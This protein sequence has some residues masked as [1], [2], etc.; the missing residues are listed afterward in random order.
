MRTSKS[1]LAGVAAGALGLALVPALGVTSANAASV[2][3]VTSPVRA[4]TV[5]SIPA[6]TL[7]IPSSVSAPTTLTVVSAPTAAAMVRINNGATPASTDDSASLSSGAHTIV[8]TTFATVSGDDTVIG[9]SADTAGSYTVRLANG[10][11]TVTAAF[12]TTGVPTSLTLTPATQTVLVGA[13]AT[14]TATLKDA[15]GNT[16]QPAVVDSVALSDNTDDTLSTATL[17][18]A[19]LAKGV[20]E[21]TLDTENNPAGTTTV[22]ATPQGTLPGSGVT[23][24]TASV[25]KSGTVSNVAIAGISVTTPAN[26]VN[27]GTFPTKTAQV[28]EGTTAIT[29]TVDDTTAASAGNALRFKAVLSAGGTLNGAAATAGAPQYLNVTTDAA[30]KATIAMTLGGAAVI[31]NSTLT[32][33]QVNVLNADVTGPVTETITWKTPVVQAS[34]VV[35]T[36]SGSIV[37]QVG[38]STSVSVQV[39][40]SFGVPQAGWTVVAYRDSVSAANLL[41]SATTSAA[42][43]ASV[44]VSPLST[45]TNG[46]SE[47]YVFTAQPPVGG[48]AVTAA[49]NLIV[50]YTTSGGVTSMS[51]TPSTGA[52]FTNTSTSIATLPAIL[53]PSGGTIGSATSA[54]VYT[55]ASDSVSPAASTP[56]ATFTVDTTPDNATVVTVPEGVKVSATAPTSSTLWS[57]GAQSATIVDGGLAYVWATKTGTHDVTFTSGGLTVTGKVVVGNSAAD[58]YNINITPAEQNLARGAFGTA[59][60]SLTDVFGNAVAGSATGGAINTVKVAAAGEILLGGFTATQDVTVGATGTA[61]VTVIA[62]NTSGAGTLTVT[63]ASTVTGVNAWGT[64][65][66]PPTGAPAPKV[67]AVAVVT[68]GEAPVTK[69]ITITGERT[70]VSGKSGIRVTGTVV[71]IENGKTVKPFI[72]F[73]GQTTFTEGSARPA[74]SDAAVT[75]QRKTGKRVTVYLEL[76]DD[77]SVRSNRV[78]IQ[79]K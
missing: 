12:T 1:I 18:S 64:T 68:V 31:N 56:L 3:G 47:T 29:V 76:S 28:A 20:A 49:N 52:A 51:I 27:A 66:S 59:T 42:G 13:T 21:F 41:S 37:A 71:G 72:R 73:P 57:A 65:Y 7:A 74:I 77:A 33:T 36:P 48:G 79:A 19:N 38:A 69:S 26:A 23:A 46:Q 24:A 16:T 14:L 32:L 43:A 54:G 6:A 39:D 60:V 30:K 75:W 53:V 34:N 10:S 22:T 63:P 17:S 9:I 78:T 15:A 5:G 50:S 44:T 8:S 35:P 70:T 61:S 67:S 11:D 40:D 25:T 4:G 55:V 45:T 58:A 62:S 2:S